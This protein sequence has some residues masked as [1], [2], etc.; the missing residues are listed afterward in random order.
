[1]EFQ[2]TAGNFEQIFR[3]K[4]QLTGESILTL[5]NALGGTME[6]IKDAILGV[7]R[8]RVDTSAFQPPLRKRVYRDPTA[9]DK[10][11]QPLQTI[12]L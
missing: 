9:Y 1:M 2:E 6:E 8:E 11:A 10:N 5:Q 7:K 4:G 12:P 3:Q